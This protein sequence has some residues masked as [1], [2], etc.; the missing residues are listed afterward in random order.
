M[1]R[2]LHER[3]ARRAS[4]PSEYLSRNQHGRALRL[5]NPAAELPAGIQVPGL[6]K[7]TA[8][9][10]QDAPIVENETA[11]AAVNDFPRLVDDMLQVLPQSQQVFIVMGPERL[12]GSDVGS[13]T[14]SSRDFAI[15][16]P[17]SV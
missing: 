11:V 5:C 16:R 17:L 12:A 2:A 7:R 3:S 9:D 10:L 14:R 1:T 6:E 4:V 13:S 8:P 15:A